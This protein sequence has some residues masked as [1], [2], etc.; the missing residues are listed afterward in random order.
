MTKS[1]LYNTE[2]GL[3]WKSL[4]LWILKINN[5]QLKCTSQLTYL[6]KKDWKAN[7]TSKFLNK[8]K[9]VKKFSSNEG[10]LNEIPIPLKILER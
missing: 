2:F 3:L 7:S 6:N 4:N 1:V 8:Y 5:V 9:K 10:V